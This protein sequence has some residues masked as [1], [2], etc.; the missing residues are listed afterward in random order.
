[1]NGTHSRT[2]SRLGQGVFFVKEQFF[3]VD[4]AQE[5]VWPTFCA[6]PTSTLEL[7]PNEL[8]K[9]EACSATIENLKFCFG[10]KLLTTTNRYLGLAPPQALPG[11]VIVIFLGA[12]VPHVLRKYG[13]HYRL[14]G[15][16]YV[17]GF[18]G[19]EA[20][21]VLRKE[22]TQK[23]PGHRVRPSHEG[24]DGLSLRWFELK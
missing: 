15:E 5:T 4:P 22:I 3:I 21:A 8:A 20:L 19:G 23:V 11:D 14:V 2:Q 12:P 13:G 1:M 16:C 24:I 7:G 9:R 6:L 17:H 10:R 18:M